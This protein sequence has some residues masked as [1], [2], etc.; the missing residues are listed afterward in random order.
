MAVLSVSTGKL[1]ISILAIFYSIFI[2]KLAIIIFASNEITKIAKNVLNKKPILLVLYYYF[3][4]I[5]IFIKEI[6]KTV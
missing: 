2:F 6:I 4:H 5:T 1:I 3:L